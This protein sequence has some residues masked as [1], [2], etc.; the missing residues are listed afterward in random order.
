MI[1]TKSGRGGRR[2][3]GV[4]VSSSATMDSPYQFM[5]EQQQFGQGERAYEWQYDNTDTWGP[6]LDGTY[7]DNFWNVKTQRWDNGPMRSSKENRV[8][9]YLRTGTTVT[10]NVN[11]SGNYDKGSFR[12][13]LTNMDNGGVMPNT[14]TNQKSISINSEYN[15]TDKIKISAN[16]SYIRT[17]SPNKANVTGSNSIINSLLFNFPTNLQPLSDMKNY[18][19]DG[20]E[21]TLMNGAIMRDNGID[22]AEDNPWWRTYE[23]INRFGRDNFLVNCS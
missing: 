7:T 11:I 4:S 10:T 8:K 15:L 13:S 5:E 22:V 19:L 16:S 6:A 17:Y 14:K 12:L 1:T 2:G 20:F 18:W 3:I 9:A 21:G 23:M